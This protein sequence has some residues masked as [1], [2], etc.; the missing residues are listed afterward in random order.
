M[1]LKALLVLA[2]MFVAACG[3][4]K[5]E[6]DSVDEVAASVESGI[7]IING[8]A[9]DQSNGSFADNR[10]TLETYAFQAKNLLLPQAWAASCARAG[11]E[12]CVAGVKTENYVSCDLPYSFRTLSGTVNL[13]YSDASC[14]LNNTGDRVERSYD[15]A[16]NGLAGGV[17]NISSASHVDYRG[18]T[19]GGGG[20]LT[21]TAGGWL[22]EVMGKRKVFTRKSRELLNVSSRTISPITITGSLARAGRQV[23]G[24]S[25]EVIHNKAKFV[26][27]YSPNTL[28]YSSA[29]CHPTSGSLGVVYSGSV[30]GAATV[31][32]N[33]C[34]MA[35]LE[36]DGLSRQ[37]TLD[38]CE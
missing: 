35:N 29:C 31:T 20:R 28:A 34:G 4:K 10:K 8:I 6:D 14:G 27:T 16:L 11:A 37:I 23:T 21:K 1:K 13:S 36:K 30:S 22:I 5:T 9:D 15:L 2:L 32:F 18:N 26:A 24:G 3:E 12:P 17:L 25:Y 33:G 38:Y 7:T 19:L